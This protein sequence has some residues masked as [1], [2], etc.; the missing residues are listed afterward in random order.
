MQPSTA[1]E[2]H[3]RRVYF[4]HVP[5]AELILKVI[6]IAMDLMNMILK[7]MGMAMVMVIEMIAMMVMR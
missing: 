2:S 5:Y 4:F 6:K 7:V 3:Q 1:K